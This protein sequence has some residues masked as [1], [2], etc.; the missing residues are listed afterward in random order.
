MFMGSDGVLESSCTP[1]HMLYLREPLRHLLIS[2]NQNM[3]LNAKI[4]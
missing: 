3:I 1:D 2:E 4:E